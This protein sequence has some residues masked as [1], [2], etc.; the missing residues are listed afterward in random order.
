MNY[1]GPYRWLLV[2]YVRL[3][4]NPFYPL[5]RILKSVIPTT[6]TLKIITILTLVYIGLIKTIST[7]SFPYPDK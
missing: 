4:L 6:Q 3:R 7:G 5:Y 1:I 2:Y